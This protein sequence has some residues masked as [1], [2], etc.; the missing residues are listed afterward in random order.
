MLLK[1][2]SKNVFVISGLG[3]DERIFYKL[4]FGNNNVTHL[5]WQQPLPKESFEAYATRLA[6]PIVGK[7]NVVLVGLSFGGMVATEIARQISC[8]KV[9][10]ISSAKHGGEIP[11]IY[12]AAG[13][14][15]LH[16][17]I[18]AALLKQ[19]NIV[20][21]TLFSTRAQQDRKLV[22]NMIQQAD[23]VFLN[24][25]INKIVH[26]PVKPTPANL[27]H[28]HGTADRILPYK[29]VQAT[30]TVPAGRHLMIVNNSKE[31]QSYLNL[32][33]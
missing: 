26:L 19:A 29:N 15:G 27:V 28:I 2:M 11:K 5:S 4:N 22:H 20:T 3:A 1:S 31:I 14:I 16:K 30:H 33:L 7:Q 23:T 9:I 32:Y 25:A 6:L 18:S 13:K 12:K 17:I 8:E 21:N 24:W 10:L